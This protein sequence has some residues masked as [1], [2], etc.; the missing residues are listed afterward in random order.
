VGGAATSAAKPAAARLGTRRSSAFP[1]L[2]GPNRPGLGSGVICVTRA[3]H[4]GPKRGT[5]GVLATS[6]T[7]GAGRRGGVTTAR[8]FRPRVRSTAYNTWRNRSGGAHR[9]FRLGWRAVHGCWRRRRRRITDGDRRCSWA[10]RL[11]ALPELWVSSD[12]RGESL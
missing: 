5:R 4:L 2:R 7:A 12:R 10:R 1:P 6:T 9:E 11:R 3:I 8:A